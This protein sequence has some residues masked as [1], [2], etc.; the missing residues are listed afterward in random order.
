MQQVDEDIGHFIRYY[1][2]VQEERYWEYIVVGRFSMQIFLVD[3]LSHGE[4]W[5]LAQKQGIEN[6][7]D[8]VNVA[9]FSDFAC[10]RRE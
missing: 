3:A 5:R 7:A 10:A 2:A 9:M 8:A 4:V 6:C 1:F